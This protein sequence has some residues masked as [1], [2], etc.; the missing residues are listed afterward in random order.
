MRVLASS[1]AVIVGALA[2]TLGALPSAC[3]A[4]TPAEELEA[5]LPRRGRSPSD[6]GSDGAAPANGSSSGGS[7]SGGSSSGGTEPPAA[8]CDR[9]KPFGPLARLTELDAYAY[10]GVPRLTADER[11]LYF[12]MTGPA[13][14]YD[15]DVVV[16]TRSSRT[17]P[18]GAPQPVTALN[19][20][21]IDGDGA[22]TADGLSIYFT[23]WRGEAGG[24]LADVYVATR[25][26]PTATFGPPLLVAS[27]S[28]ADSEYTAS[29]TGSEGG[30]LWFTAYKPA[31]YGIFRAPRVGAGFGTAVRATELGTGTWVDTSPHP[32]EDGRSIVFSSDRP[33]G[34]GLQDLWIVE[35]AQ[36][37]QPFGAPRPLTELNS[38][39]S[40][41]G[42]WLSADG[43]RITI[44]TDRDAPATYVPKFYAAAR[45][46]L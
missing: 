2:L 32:S 9:T 38:P 33:G 1:A 29:Y 41:T 18:F 36:V 42:A 43:C 39:H 14:Q 45:P 15:G 3:A 31:E 11:Q 19:S 34:L 27:V 35:R 6:G 40:E 21:T 4:P 8:P 26:T 25:S 22:P 23:S 24:G 28:T 16:A 12:N 20:T 46:A 10:Y 17:E 13:S 30:A 44:A 37:G 5:D 7:S